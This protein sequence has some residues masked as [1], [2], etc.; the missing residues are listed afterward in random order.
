MPQVLSYA[1]G[2]S[3]AS[4]VFPCEGVA[5]YLRCVSCEEWLHTSSVFSCDGWSHASGVFPCEGVASYLRCVLIRRR[6]LM[7]QVCCHVRAWLHASGVF[8]CEGVASCLRCVLI[9]K[10]GF[11]SQVCSYF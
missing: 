6:G 4:G 2:W 5:S 10:R 9:S 1:N 3:H 11:M 7:P 8:L